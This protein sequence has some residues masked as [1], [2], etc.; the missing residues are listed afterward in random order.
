MRAHPKYDEIKKLTAGQRREILEFALE[1]SREM[2]AGIS[3]D[4]PR[5]VCNR[6]DRTMSQWEKIENWDDIKVGD[7]VRRESRICDREENLTVARINENEIQYD[8]GEWDY[9]EHWNYG[10]TLSRRVP[11]THVEPPLSIESHLEVIEGQ[12]EHITALLERMSK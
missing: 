3:S 9:K 7:Q 6:K 1:R 4:D 8:D 5:S 11:E 10:Y 12:L 2:S